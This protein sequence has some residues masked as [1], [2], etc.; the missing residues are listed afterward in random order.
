MTG[1]SFGPGA[2]EPDMAAETRLAAWLDGELDKE[3]TQ[4]MDA[5]ISADPHLASQVERWRHVDALVRSAVP[6][7]PVPAALLQ[8]LGLSDEPAPATV[9]DLASARRLRSTQQASAATARWSGPA[10]WRIAAQVL[11]IGGVGI[12]ASLWFAPRQAAPEPSATYRT[13]SDAPRTSRAATPVISAVVVFTDD[14]QPARAR[15]IAARAGA[16]LIGEPTSGG[17]WKASIAPGRRDAVLAVLRQQPEV[18]M[19]EPIDGAAP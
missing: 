13:L 18:T 16:R 12:G 14:T 19:A 1:K 4:D 6:E 2:S 3:G 11:V 10:L 5:R 9:V 8:R 15:A 7:E 17:G